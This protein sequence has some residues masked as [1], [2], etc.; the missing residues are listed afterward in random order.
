MRPSIAGWFD[1]TIQLW[2]AVI[3]RDSL[4][5]EERTYVPVGVPVG[6]AINRSKTA[7]R[8][9]DGGLTQRGTLRWYGLPT[10]DVQ[11]RDIA[12]IVSGP[13]AGHS[14]EVDAVPPHPRGH[15]TQVDCVEWSGTLP[16]QSETSDS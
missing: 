11:P 7:T 15:H 4:G 12:Q 5:T 8:P 3:D 9:D 1:S 6:A 16:E 10:L 14:W 13:D 2:R